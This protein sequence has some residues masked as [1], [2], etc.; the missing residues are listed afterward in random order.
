MKILPIVTSIVLVFSVSQIANAGSWQGYNGPAH[1]AKQG[2]K[3]NHKLFKKAGGSKKGGSHKAKHHS[4]SSSNQRYEPKRYGHGQYKGKHHG[5]RNHGSGN[6][7]FLGGLLFGALAAHA[8]TRSVYD[9]E[10]SYS[11][12]STTTIYQGS[13]VPPTRKLDER[14]YR[15]RLILGADGSCIFVGRDDEGKEY[16]QQLSPSDCY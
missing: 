14:Q 13:A 3:K 8:L 15:E 6:G 11:A 1:G 12:N 16:W 4:R 5:H 9:S 10:P 2:Q 7:L